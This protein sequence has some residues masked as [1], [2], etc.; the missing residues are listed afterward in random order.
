MKAYIFTLAAAAL[1][2]GVSSCG[3]EWLDL[4]PTNAVDAETALST[5]D[6]M[7]A[8]RIGMYQA[9][10]GTSDYTDYYARNMVVYGDTRADDVQ[11]N[12]DF[13][14]NRGSLFYMME[15]RTASDFG[16][17]TMPWQSPYMVISRASHIIDAFEKGL[18]DA[19]DADAAAAE[20]TAAAEA[21]VLRAYCL[22]DLTRIYGRPYTQDGG[23]SLGVPVVDGVLE[24]TAKPQRST[25][26]ECYAQI[27]KD[28]AA[29]IA[30][31]ALVEDTYQGYINLWAAKALQVRVL[32]TKGDYA[33][34]L[35]SAQDI[36]SR[37]PYQLWT[38]GE[39]ATAWNAASPAHLSE[40]IF[41]MGITGSSDW[42]DREGLAYLMSEQ[43]YGDLVVTKAFSDFISADAQDCR[44]DILLASTDATNVKNFGTTPVFINKYQD[45]GDGRY[46]NVTLLRLSEVYLSAAEAAFALGK[47]Q[48][49]ADL[50]NA[51]I[52]HRT[53]DEAKLVDASS[54]TDERI[55][56][57]RRK[58]LVGEGQRYFDMLRRGETICRYTDVNNRGWH[59]I[60]SEE[61]RQYS[62]TDNRAYPA[63]PQYEING[64]PDIKQNPGWGN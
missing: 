56:T 63:I 34:A 20:A 62:P 22:F 61:A 52:S 50:L 45:G 36:I 54:I 2:T 4:K 49:A 53:A 33:G 11:Y 32:L 10:K 25:V 16:R 13:G 6:D 29:A 39:Y 12:E 15:Q 27:E 14:S 48:D 46:A 26:A 60:L 58:E 38:P 24:S 18:S 28:L 37:S 19:D 47:K 23:Q 42:T 5:T 64:N 57:E 31:N 30:S 8:A 17:T 41:E 43:G 7:E 1:A 3:D 51:I 55:Q 9:F 44:N 40:T 59:A 21:R 35:A